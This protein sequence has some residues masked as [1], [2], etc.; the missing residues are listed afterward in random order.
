[1]GETAVRIGQLAGYV[2]AGTVEFLVDQNRSFYFLEM[3][4]RLQV[5]HPVTELVT[6]IDLVK[7]QIRVAAGEPLC[8]H[9]EEIQLHGAALE[10]RIYAEDPANGFFPSP[11]RI[12]RLQA[13]AGP[14]IRDD[15][16]V[17]EGW[18]VPLEYDPLL[19]KLVVWGHNRAE[20]IARMGRALNEYEIA[21]I[22]TNIGFFRRLIEHPD[23]IAGRIDTG[24]IERL[25]ERGW[26][27]NGTRS[28]GPA[29]AA[30][31]AAALHAGYNSAVPENSQRA[32]SVRNGGWK[33]SGRAAL[34]NNW[35]R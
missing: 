24:F 32:T 18:T 31:L 12:T 25:I 10:C 29:L 14:G 11:G 16:G 23:F 1:M 15:S 9:Q 22:R 33:R 34:L 30:M 7:E 27:S 3:N 5:E 19:S 2:N 20:A 35:P 17:Y 4:T 13:P 8:C 28:E 26:P 21:G 6:G